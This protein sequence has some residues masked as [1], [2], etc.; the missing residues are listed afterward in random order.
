MSK[1]PPELIMLDVGVRLMDDFEFAAEV[2]STQSRS[3]SPSASSSFSIRDRTRCKLVAGSIRHRSINFQP[4]RGILY[5]R[6]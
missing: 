2:P 1:S 3:V 6:F 5:V 4:Q